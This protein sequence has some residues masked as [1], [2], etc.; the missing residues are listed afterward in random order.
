MQHQYCWAHIL[1]DSKE[2]AQ[3]YGN[4]GLKIHQALKK[5]YKTA[6]THEQAY[7]SNKLNNSQT[8]EAIHQLNTL[9]AQLTKQQYKHSRVRKSLKHLHNRDLD[10]LFLF[11]Q[12]NADSTNNRS[13]RALRP[14]VIARHISKGSTSLKGAKT[15][16][17]LNSIYQTLKI[18]TNNFQK[19]NLYTEL[20]K[21]LTTTQN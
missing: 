11:I 9:I 13:E 17:T 8:E 5:I 19:T 20:K 6:K 7:H 10:K 1:Q 2:L 12:T 18:Q 14:L 4:E 15:T 3:Y 21:I 16:M